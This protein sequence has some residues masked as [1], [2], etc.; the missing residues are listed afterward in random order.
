MESDPTLLHV[1]RFQVELT[2][3]LLSGQPGAG[4]GTVCGAAFSECSGLE[5]T[6]ETKVIKEG[7]RNYG[8]AQRAGPV[9]FATVILKRGLT[10]TRDMWQWFSLV[11]EQG[12][13]TNRATAVINLFDVSGKAVMAW[14]LDRAMAV[15][16]KTADLNARG[17][18]VGVE[19]LH[20]AHEGM[21]AVKPTAENL[22][23]A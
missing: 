11:S 17:T 4:S 14:Q 9:T 1:F 22:G 20:L 23:S 15:K 18:E 16:F 8:N 7:G 6:M 10:S 5:A 13:Y 12:G 19:E 21:T 2:R 3:T